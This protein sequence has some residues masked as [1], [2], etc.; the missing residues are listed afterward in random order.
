M[1]VLLLYLCVLFI[2]RFCMAS[3]PPETSRRT[4]YSKPFM[5]IPRVPFMF[6]SVLLLV[7][8]ASGTLLTLNIIPFGTARAAADSAVLTYKGD[9]YRTGQYTNETILNK[10]NVNSS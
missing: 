7:I 6:F 3:R 4:R 2:R 9:T 8:V 1:P 5:K 10:S